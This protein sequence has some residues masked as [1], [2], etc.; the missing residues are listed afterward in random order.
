MRVKTK[1]ASETTDSFG[2]AVSA[3]SDPTDLPGA[4]CFT[5]SVADDI[6][7]GRPS[8][9]SATANLYVP[10]GCLVK[11]WRGALV[12]LDGETFEWHVVGDPLG[13]PVWL[14]PGR[15]NLV[16]GLRRSDG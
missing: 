9:V 13:Y 5:A 3:W 6:E 8:G 4:I 12:A 10:K 14:T 11:D 2:N 16:V 1:V 7:E 15:Y